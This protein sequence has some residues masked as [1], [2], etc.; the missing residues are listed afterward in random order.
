MKQQP[1]LTDSFGRKHTYLRISLTEQCN[2]RCSY[3]MPQEGLPLMPKAHLMQA[4]ELFE[5]AKLF[6]T[7]GVTKIRLTGGEPLVR[8]DFPLILSKLS[9]LPVTLSITSNGISIERHFE[10]LKRH[11][12]QTINLSLDTLDREKF[13]KITFR[14]YFEQVYRN[15]FRLLE[16]GFKVKINVV[17]MKG[18]NDD[19]ISAFIDLTRDYPFIVRFIEFMPFDG[20]GWNREKTVTYQEILEKVETHFGKE[21]LQKLQDAAHDTTKNFKIQGFRGSFGIIGTVTN[22]FCDSCNRIRLTANGKLKN[23]LFSGSETDLLTPFRAGA[24]LK[25]LIQET[26]LKKHAVRSG[27]QSPDEFNDLSKHSK[28]RSMIR[29]GG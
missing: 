2:L 8:K 24:D 14:D 1:I 13:K 12:V 23:C 9:E 15:C 7:A 28:N 29:I 22:P 17:L 4:E 5:I 20:N 18:V 25:P 26:V 6:V 3:C 19:E 11:G 10:L 21:K 27:L 16:E